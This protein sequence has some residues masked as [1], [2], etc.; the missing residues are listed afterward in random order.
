MVYGHTSLEQVPDG[1]KVPICDRNVKRSVLIGVST[2][3]ST[4]VNPQ[5][6]FFN[7]VMVVFL[8]GFEYVI[9]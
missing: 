7:V 3:Q 2:A 5:L 8:A 9:N 4:D 1:V 6:D